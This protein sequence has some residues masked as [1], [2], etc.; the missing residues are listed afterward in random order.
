MAEYKTASYIHHSHLRA[1]LYTV[2]IQIDAHC[3]R[4]RWGGK[5]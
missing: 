3:N 5:R 4:R 2:E 1:N